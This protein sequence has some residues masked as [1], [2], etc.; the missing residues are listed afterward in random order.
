MKNKKSKQIVKELLMWAFAEEL[1]NNQD[2]ATKI[3]NILNKYK[4]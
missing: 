3:Y 2:K 1:N 4:N